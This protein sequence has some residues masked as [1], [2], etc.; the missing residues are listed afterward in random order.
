MVDGSWQLGGLA[1]AFR[2]EMLLVPLSIRR[3]PE[4]HTARGA[5]SHGHLVVH[6]E[7]VEDVQVLKTWGGFSRETRGKW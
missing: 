3:P 2:D 1:F 7:K 6:V 5:L 4:R